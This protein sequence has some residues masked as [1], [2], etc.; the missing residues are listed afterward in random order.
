MLLNGFS[1][2]SVES[3]NDL[4]KK[5]KKTQISHM[6]SEEPSSECEQNQKQNSNGDENP[7]RRRW[8][9]GNVEVA[10]CGRG[11]FLPVLFANC[12][13]ELHPSRHFRAIEKWG[14]RSPIGPG[15]ED[16]ELGPILL[17]QGCQCSTNQGP[18]EVVKK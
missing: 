6:T 10:S 7:S 2:K 12:E 3:V 17:Q 16:E 8:S 18:Q 9:A 1:E 5:K 14:R 15:V 4:S 13:E 11:V